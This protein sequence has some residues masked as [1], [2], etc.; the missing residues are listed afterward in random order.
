MKNNNNGSSRPNYRRTYKPTTKTFIAKAYGLDL[1]TFNKWLQPILRKIGQ[2][3]GRLF[4]PYQIKYIVKIL[5]E[6]PYPR[7]LK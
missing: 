1:R 3:H 6:P 4:T 7:F 2:P 5:G